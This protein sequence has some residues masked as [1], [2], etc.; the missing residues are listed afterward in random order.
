MQEEQNADG[1]LFLCLPDGRVEQT[2]AEHEVNDARRQQLAWEHDDIRVPGF[3]GTFRHEKI[4][5][6]PATGRGVYPHL[7][8][9]SH[10]TGP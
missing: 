3:E 5:L 9:P 8:P 6:D 2:A 4:E 1:A 7:V 10:R